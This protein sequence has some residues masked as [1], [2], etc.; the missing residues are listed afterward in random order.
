MRTTLTVATVITLAAAPATAQ[1][2]FVA[3]DPL[4]GAGAITVDTAQNLAFLDMTAA[5]GISRTDMPV[6]LASNPQYSGWRYAT[7]AEVVNLINNSGWSPLVPNA[8]GADS[9]IYDGDGSTARSFLDDYIGDINFT[10]SFRTRGA[11]T[12][13]LANGEVVGVDFEASNGVDGFSRTSLFAAGTNFFDDS[14]FGHWLVREP[15]QND[16]ITYQGRLTD[17]NAPVNGQADFQVSVKDGFDLQIPG[18]FTEFLNID[19]ASGLF[20]LDIPADLPGISDPD[21]QI[22]IGVRFPAG[23]GLFESLAPY[24]ALT[25]TTRALEADHATTALAADALSNEQID[26][27]TLNPPYT[28]YGSGYTAPTVSRQGNLVTL[29]GLA[30]DNAMT[31][32]LL[33]GTIPPE[34]RPSGRQIF[35][36][37]GSAGVFR[38]DVTTSGE[39]R[40]QGTPGTFPANPQ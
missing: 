10:P 6:Q 25:P 40:I 12:G 29:E 9:L 20:S 23:T 28:P 39:V 15:P 5:S 16:S 37:V 8:V 11:S 30:S 35:L 1:T 22:E 33:I 34:Y 13:W 21:A 17:N 26:L 31:G 27:I 3:D 36:Q 14:D 2:L 18:G 19:V 32:T 4:F 24:Q 7:R 38:V